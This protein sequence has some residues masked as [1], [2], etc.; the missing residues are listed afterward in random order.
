[1]AVDQATLWRAIGRFE[2]DR[3][4]DRRMLDDHEE[5]LTEVE[6]K[7]GILT[8]WGTR[9]ALLILLWGGALMLN[10]NPE[11]KAEVVSL[12]IKQLAK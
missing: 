1:M 7:V 5:R 12:I 2:A 4:A 8:T 11:Q 6:Q 10:L 9:G 3:D